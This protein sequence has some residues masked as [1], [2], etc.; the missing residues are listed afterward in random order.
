MRIIAFK[1]KKSYEKRKS[2]DWESNPG[3][4]VWYQAIRPLDYWGSIIGS[5]IRNKSF[6]C[7]LI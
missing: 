2:L 1:V 5:M 4:Y 3:A 7:V 6:K